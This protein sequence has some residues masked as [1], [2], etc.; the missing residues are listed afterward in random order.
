MGLC[1]SIIKIMAISMLKC[2]RVKKKS[3]KLLTKKLRR[4]GEIY[5]SNNKK[6]PTLCKNVSLTDIFS[7]PLTPKLIHFKPYDLSICII[8]D[9]SNVTKWCWNIRWLLQYNLFYIDLQFIKEEFQYIKIQLVLGLF[10]GAS[11][12]SLLFFVG[13][14]YVKIIFGL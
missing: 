1:I 4:E 11:C 12:L 14:Q 13:F 8:F 7:K 10:P 9:S 6:R 2:K 3:A 5:G